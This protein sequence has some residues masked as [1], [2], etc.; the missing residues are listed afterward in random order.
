MGKSKEKEIKM[1]KVFFI[2][3][4]LLFASLPSSSPA[5]VVVAA[6]CSRNDVGSAV[7]LAR[8]GDTVAIPAC[9]DGVTWTSQLAVTKGITLKGAGIGQTVLIDNVSSGAMLSFNVTGADWRV[10]GIEFRGGTTGKISSYLFFGEGN[11]HA[12]RIDNNKFYNWAP[13]CG[14]NCNRAVWLTGDLM[15]VI[16]S[17]TFDNLATWAQTFDVGH[18]SWGGVGAYGDNSW[19]DSDNFGTSKFIFIEDNTF[20]SQK[21]T[22][23]PGVLDA[24]DGA[25]VVFRYNTLN[26]DF[27][28]WHGTESSQRHRG[29]RAFE[30]YSNHFY[31]KPGGWDKAVFIRSGTAL[32]YNNTLHTV[33]NASEI[34]VVAKF[35]NYRDDASYAPWG[36][37]NGSGSY[38][39]NQSGG[40][41][42]CI[43]QPG[44][45][46]SNV[47]SGATPSPVAWPN[48]TLAPVYV[49][50]N[51]GYNAAQATSDSTNVQQ[52]RDYYVG[53]AKSGYTAYTY[54]HPLRTGDSNGPS[55]PTGLK[56]I[57]N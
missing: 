27:I 14:S 57:K 15:G 30:V 1:K 55:A 50:N 32:V 3:G 48:Q 31:A 52:N 45:G 2:I 10:T 23:F 34:S 13:S 54:P 24:T 16:D 26:G 43:D 21:A 11:S 6:S 18:P 49:W 17:N 39:G 25:R 29:G 35:I 56:A 4:I 47:L 42:P 44:R 40:G 38:D 7:N 19:A 41:Y 22:P 36:Q 20:Y 33:K 5:A 8:G 37:C 12:F 51:T 28:G 9:K 46:K 53:T